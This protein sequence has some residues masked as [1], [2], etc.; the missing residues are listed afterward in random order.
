M[1]GRSRALDRQ[2]PRPASRLTLG[3]IIRAELSIG[4]RFARRASRQTQTGPWVASMKTKWL[5]EMKPEG[6]NV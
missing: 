6:A 3:S 5:N 4:R 1:S 2:M